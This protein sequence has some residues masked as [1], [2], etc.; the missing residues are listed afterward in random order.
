MGKTLLTS[1]RGVQQTGTT[2]AGATQYAHIGVA[3]LQYNSTEAAART[4]FHSAGTFSRLYVKITANT[5]TAASTIRTRKTGVNGNQS[6]P[7]PAGFTGIVEDSSNTDTIVSGDYMGY[8]L[9]TGSGGTLTISILSVIWDA[10][11]NVLSRFVN[12][13]YAV[14]GASVTHFLPIAGDRSGT[15]SN[16]SVC[17]Q[18]LKRAVTAK[19]A[20]VYVTSN[21]RTTTTTFTVRKSVADTALTISVTGSS[22]SIGLFEN[23]ANAIAFVADDEIAWELTT[24]SGT[25]TLAVDA[26]FLTLEH[27]T[28]GIITAGAIG[29]SSTPSISFNT[30]YY[31]ALGGAIKVETTEPQTQQK[32]R[33][34]FDFSNLTVN[35]TANSVNGASTLRTRKNGANGSQSVPIPASFTGIAVDITNEESF[36]STDEINCQLVTGGTSGTMEIRQ[37]GVWLT[38]GVILPIAM[39][40][41]SKV[42]ANKF[43]TKV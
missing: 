21:A 26:L 11:T 25:T 5:A 17:E 35:I 18:S 4:R 14:A 41:A 6:L 22:T 7:I 12:E 3:L 10:A 28:H 31:I 30:T 39:T 33:D 40:V 1:V 24:G 19:N 16:E 15:T 23:T 27:A 9:V 37:V 43:I 42:L 2:T 34:S 13:G 20:G 32:V 36:I 8:Q 38:E 29:T